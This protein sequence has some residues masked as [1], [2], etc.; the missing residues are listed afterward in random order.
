[1]RIKKLFGGNEVE[2]NAKW[3]FTK[4]VFG[5]EWV[6]NYVVDRTFNFSHLELRIFSQYKFI[7]LHIQ[8]RYLNISLWHLSNFR[9][10]LLDYK[11]V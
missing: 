6:S 11:T 9:K 5:F 1:M 4:Q 7:E 8:L 10:T 2:V 3:A